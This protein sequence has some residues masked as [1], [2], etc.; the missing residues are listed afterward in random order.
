[1]AEDKED[2]PLTEEEMIRLVSHISAR[3]NLPFENEIVT[4][5]TKQT[6]YSAALA[7]LTITDVLRRFDAERG[8]L[9]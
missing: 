3:V 2:D 6:M 7:G 9:H 5:M 8:S 1:M 4:A